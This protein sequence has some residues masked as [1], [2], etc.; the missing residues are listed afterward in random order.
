MGKKKYIYGRYAAKTDIGKVR[1]NNEDQSC[2]LT[3][4]RG[5]ILLIVCDGMGGQNK[6]DLAAALTVKYI[7]QEFNNK[8]RFGGKLF[9]KRWVAKVIR[10]ANAEVFRQASSNEKYQGMGTTIT[11]VLIVNDY[12]LQHESSRRQC[13]AAKQRR[14]ALWHTRLQNNHPPSL[15][16]TVTTRKNIG[17]RT[18]RNPNG[19]QHNAE[20]GKNDQKH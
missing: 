17:H 7:T 2:A 16:A 9:T 3:N 20:C 10:G 12:G 8:D 13:R 5:N 1:L 15:I 4:T 11:L 6:G 14:N 19:A 18:Q